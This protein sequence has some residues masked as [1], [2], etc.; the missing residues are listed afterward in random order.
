[1]KHLTKIY[2]KPYIRSKRIKNWFYSN[3]R[4]LDSI[5]TLMGSGLGMSTSCAIA[6]GTD[7][8]EGDSDCA[9]CS[10]GCGYPTG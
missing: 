4:F 8:V 9:M 3:H 1:M 7:G 2:N 5:D 10:G 6:Q